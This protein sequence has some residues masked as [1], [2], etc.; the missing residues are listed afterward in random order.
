MVQTHSNLLVAMLSAIIGGTTKAVHS[1]P[2]LQAHVVNF[3]WHIVASVSV[4]AA[5]SATIGIIIK[6]G[7]EHTYRYLKRHN[8]MR[9]ELKQAAK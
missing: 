4:Y 7:T 9:K 1:Y 8:A 5:I 6:M 2:L 3:E